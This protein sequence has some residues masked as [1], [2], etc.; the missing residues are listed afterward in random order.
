MSIA[1]PAVGDPTRKDTFADPVIDKL[2]ELEAN[3]AIAASTFGLVPNGS[4]EIGSA[5]DT[6]PAGWTLVIAAGNHTAFETS[7]ANI[8][9]GAQAL[10]M[11][12]PGGVTGG[13]SATSTNYLLCSAGQKF[14]LSWLFRASVATITCTVQ[15]KWYTSSGSNVSTSTLYSKA[16][17]NTLTWLQMAAVCTPPATAV[18]FKIVLIGV[19]STTMG[20]AYW[21]GVQQ[22]PYKSGIVFTSSGT[23]FSSPGATQFESEDQAA[24]GGSGGG[25]GGA[26]AGPT[27]GSDGTA[28]GDGGDSYLGDG[29]L[30]ARGGKGGGAGGRGWGN[31]SISAG[32]AG[33]AAL[34]PAVSSSSIQGGSIAA[35][36]GTNS[37]PTTGA[38]AP[39]GGS[40][41]IPSF[42][43]I[44]P[45][46]GGAEGSTA[47][48][49]VAGTAFTGAGASGGAGGR[50]SAAGTPTSG[51]GGGGG[52][53]GER[54]KNLHSITA[55]DGNGIPVVVGAP[56]TAGAGG[57]PG[58]GGKAGGAGALGGSG[59]VKVVELG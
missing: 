42:F 55:N 52:S 12:T 43:K 31:G 34:A 53:N 5:A 6:D 38:G 20:V 19:N 4:F 14:A 50:P 22:L 1:K 57:A 26:A 9:H 28:G 23:F 51:S 21:D 25:G 33:G 58:G 39:G 10:S 13:V 17:G 35:V 29:T 47:G 37:V 40:L 16:A 46:A 3:Q 11:T 2:A 45:R 56:G 44:E 32:G 36:A 8:A 54:A 49:G 24:G 41:G 18:Y 15:V 48:P 30:K 59:W 27:D 7:A